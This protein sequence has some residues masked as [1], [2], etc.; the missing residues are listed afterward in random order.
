MFERIFF[1]VLGAAPSFTYPPK[2][3]PTGWSLFIRRSNTD[4]NDLSSRRQ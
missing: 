4:T 1:F 2:A 3:V